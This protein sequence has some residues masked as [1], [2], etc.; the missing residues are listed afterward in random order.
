MAQL[1]SLCVT[2]YPVFTVFHSLHS[3]SH[4]LTYCHRTCTS[5]KHK[6]HTTFGIQISVSLLHRDHICHLRTTDPSYHL[7]LLSC[8]KICA[9]ATTKLRI[10]LSTGAKDEVSYLI[11]ILWE[12]ED[13]MNSSLAGKCWTS[14][15]QIN[16]VS[17]AMFLGL[18]SPVTWKSPA[19]LNGTCVHG[20]R[21]SLGLV[22]SM[23]QIFW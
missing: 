13:R 5:A 10:F 20:L 21:K 19:S 2:G 17:S 4:S 8:L 9:A 15:E 14:S 23:P 1:V 11:S 22:Y 3:G 18:D 6:G 7:P 16:A 12:G